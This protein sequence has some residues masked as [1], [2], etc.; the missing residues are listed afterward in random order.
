MPLE[1]AT[2]ALRHNLRLFLGSDQARLLFFILLAALAWLAMKLSQRHSHQTPFTIHWTSGNEILPDLNG[3][4][5]VSG[6]GWDLLYHELSDDRF[7]IPMHPDAIY[8]D[9]FTP[10]QLKRKFQEQTGNIQ[11]LEVVFDKS[12]F[13]LNGARFKKVPIVN[14]AQL[15]F[16]SGF[17]FDGPIRFQP[18]SVMVVAPT[19]VLDTITVWYTTS[20]L[21]ITRKEQTE[22]PV[23]EPPSGWFVYPDKLRVLNPMEPVVEKLIRLPLK[24]RKNSVTDSLLVHP[25]VV[26]LKCQMHARHLHRLDPENLQAVVNIQTGNQDPLQPGF[27][28]VEIAQPPS[29]IKITGINPPSV[30][31]WEIAD[32]KHQQE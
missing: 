13:K 17:S 27:V 10:Q 28:P 8:T 3:I 7:S 19:E 23:A 2:Q 25:N 29:W 1:Q 12:D 5:Q 26:E 24:V 32:H 11:V 15:H 31:Y 21:V 4:L 18:D 9:A 6:T 22:I 16:D 20:N 30:Q 14:M